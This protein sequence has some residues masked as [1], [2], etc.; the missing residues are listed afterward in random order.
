MAL[1]KTKKTDIINGFKKHDKDTG[2]ARVQIALLTERI[3]AL[4]EHFKVYKK[5]HSSR[6]GLLK[7][8]GKRR[9]LL[10]YLKDNYTSVYSELV[11][12]LDL[13]K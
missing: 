3:N 8:V 13:R 2:S 10:D 12:K 5:D 9:R 11:K 1:T 4:T 6:H 7:L